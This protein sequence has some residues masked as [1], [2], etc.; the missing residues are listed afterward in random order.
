MSLPSL[1]RMSEDEVYPSSVYSSPFISRVR[2]RSFQIQFWGSMILVV[3]YEVS[4]CGPSELKLVY[5]ISEFVLKFEVRMRLP[6]LYRMSENEVYPS[7]VYSSAFISRVR[8][9]SFQIQFWGSRR[10]VVAL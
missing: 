8:M 7:S 5:R 4:W 1:Y 9:R 10:L 6:S 3:A 2:L